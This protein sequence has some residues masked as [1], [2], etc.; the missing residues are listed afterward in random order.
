MSTSFKDPQEDIQLLDIE[1]RANELAEED[2]YTYQTALIKAYQEA[3]GKVEDQTGVTAYSTISVPVRLK[4][5]L[6]EDKP[7]NISWG[8]YIEAL[9]EAYHSD[10]PRT[11][12]SSGGLS[13]DDLVSGCERA[14][15]NRLPAEALNQ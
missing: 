7:D 10:E 3:I 13:F 2:T 11:A 5:V 8:E 4:E 1:E 14:L 6:R 12:E 9:Y 15:E